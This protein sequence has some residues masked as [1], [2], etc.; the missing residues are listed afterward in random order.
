MQNLNVNSVYPIY[1]QIY[2]GRYFQDR[3]HGKGVYTWPD[4]SSYSGSVYMDKKE[5]FGVFQ[6]ANGNKFEVKTKLVE[7]RKYI[8]LCI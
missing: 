6:F 5:G 3:R 2:K 1:F 8:I 4:G 7:D